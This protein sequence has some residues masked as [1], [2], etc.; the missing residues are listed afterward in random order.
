MEPLKGRFFDIK[1]AK[2]GGKSPKLGRNTD[3]IRFAMVAIAAFVVLG[4]SNAYVLGRDL[5]WDSQEAAY[6]GYE[7]LKNGMD[8]LLTQDASKASEFFMMAESSFQELSQT[9]QHITSQ[10]NHLLAESL[11]LDTADKLI[12]GAQEVAQIGVELAE[13]MKGF[14]ELPQAAMSVV[15]GEDGNLIEALLER[16]EA[17]DEILAL[18]ASLQ[19][20]ITTLNDSILP[21]ELQAKLTGAR[22]QIGQLMAALLDVDANFDVV[23]RLLGD[24]IPHRYLVLLQNNHELRATGGF[25]GSYL[26]VD[27][28]DG[29]IIKMEAK[30]VYETDGQLRD[31]VDPPPGIDKVADRLYMRD[32][33]YS[34]DFPTSAQDIMWFLEHSKGP[35]VDTVIAIDQVVV[36]RLLTLTGTLVVPGFPFQ[37]RAENFN[38]IVS[39]YTE[40]KLSDTATPKQLLFD[41][42]PVFQKHFAGVKDLKE[43]GNLVIQLL[44][45]G[46]VQAYSLDPK[47]QDLIVRFDLD[48]AVVAADNKTDYLSV[49]TTAIGGNKSDQYMATNLHHR[50]VIDEKGVIANELT[51]KKTHTWSNS[52]ETRLENLIERY[53]TGKLTKESLY[54]VLGRGPNVDYMRVYVPKGSQLQS[55]T[56]IDLS[57][58]EVSEDLGYTVFAFTNGPIGA[59]ESKELMLRYSL[60]YKLSLRTEDNYQFI[61]EHQAGA[62]NVTLKKELITP[63]TV[64][65]TESYPPSSNTF[66]LSPILETAFDSNQIFTS[67]ISSLK[68]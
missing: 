35:S 62:E 42:I 65:I 19:R 58:I 11:Y 57:A 47:V 29:K 60:P 36:E 12:D 4:V 18:A 56:G 53:G 40:A 48:G 44:E 23:L 37:L 32:A 46:H 39:F 5:I 59:G 9:T 64:K 13:L 50:S 25:I 67:A 28:N 63:D 16:K 1:P 54:F 66:S 61:A 15:G 41:L 8:S 30:D 17:F 24:E 43:L 26:T 2:S 3:F 21:D 45:E 49:V 20:K 38:D 6:T 27:V 7:N 52:E 10:S 22:T 51:I 31:V 33:N 14:S 34:P 68:Q 55:A